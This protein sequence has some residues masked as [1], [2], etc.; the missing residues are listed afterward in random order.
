[1]KPRGIR[2]NNPLNIRRTKTVWQGMKTKVTDRSFVEFESMAYGYR[3]AWRTLFTY[4]YKHFGARKP[5]TAGHIINRWAPPSE[6]DTPAY[7]RTV[8]KLTGIGGHEHLLPPLHPCGARKLA[9][10]LAAMTVVENG[11]PPAEVDTKAIRQG[12]QMAF[13]VPFPTEDD[14]DDTEADDFDPARDEYW[15]WSPLAYGE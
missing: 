1:M 4:F 15:D 3:A 11:I 13:E 10:L 12:Y 9:S 6:N 8:L 2:N 7:I 14:D 5:V